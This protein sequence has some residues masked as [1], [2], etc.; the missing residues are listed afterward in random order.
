VKITK[1]PRYVLVSLSLLAVAPVIYFWAW[2]LYLLVTA[3][4]PEDRCP[5]HERFNPVVWQDT[6]QVYFPAQAARVYG[7]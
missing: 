1:P 7:R 5:G 3:P 6:I 2:P 4:L